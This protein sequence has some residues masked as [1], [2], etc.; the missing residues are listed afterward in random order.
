M[1]I[2]KK[3]LADIFLNWL[4]KAAQDSAEAGAHEFKVIL[5]KGRFSGLNITLE[6][7]IRS[8]KALGLEDEQP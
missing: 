2:T 4:H 5:V 6:T 1:R 8:A 7:G 3:K